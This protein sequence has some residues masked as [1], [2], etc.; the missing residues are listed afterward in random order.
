[1]LLS[2]TSP[3]FGTLE[4]QECIT[5]EKPALDQGLHTRH[6]LYGLAG[7][8]FSIGTD[9][10]AVFDCSQTSLYPCELFCPGEAVPGNQHSEAVTCLLSHQPLITPA[11]SQA[12][13]VLQG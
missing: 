7:I 9:M 4:A 12:P 6:S 11:L 10:D 3:F 2:C 5:R 13:A 1:M 8:P